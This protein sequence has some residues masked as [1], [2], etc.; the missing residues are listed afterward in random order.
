MT[1]HQRDFK[2]IFPTVILVTKIEDYEDLN[3]ELS[4]EVDEVRATTENGRPAAWSCDLYT[5]IGNN[6]M[7]HQRPG[8][9][10]LNEL[11]IENA[12]RY[13]RALD[14]PMDDYGVAM[15]MCWLNA[16][17][18][19]HS[20]ERHTHINY[21]FNGIYYLKA[22]PGASKLITHSPTSDALMVPQYRERTEL[23]TP[24]MEIEPE[25][26]LMLIFKGN[27]RHSVRA[28]EI[29]EERISIS[30]NAHFARR[31]ST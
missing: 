29:D 14:Y 28:S 20:Q 5:T 9:R 21:V 1:Q 27:L 7:L 12:E 3:A 6:F 8:F 30:M 24:Y 31:Q 22:P 19:G 2:L 10:R 23:N 17:R 18:R 16:Y 25:E 11:F 15:D 4:R 26:G 13:G